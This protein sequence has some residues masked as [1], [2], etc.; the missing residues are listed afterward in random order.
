MAGGVNCDLADLTV[1]ASVDDVAPWRGDV[2]GVQYGPQYL[3]ERPG[4][5]R[6]KV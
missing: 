4:G 3:T 2:N 6:E 1:V 5:G